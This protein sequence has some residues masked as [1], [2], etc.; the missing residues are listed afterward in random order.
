MRGEG[1]TKGGRG[2][3][4]IHLEPVA[5]KEEIVVRV[6][7]GT[8]IIIIKGLRRERGRA[9]VDERGNLGEPSAWELRARLTWLPPYPAS[10][11]LRCTSLIRALY[12]ASPRP[13]EEMKES[14]GMR[15]HEFNGP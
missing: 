11:K 13:S 6:P 2:Q 7:E 4:T 10:M 9:G 15:F 3:R 8:S 5:I 1:R 14:I 12:V